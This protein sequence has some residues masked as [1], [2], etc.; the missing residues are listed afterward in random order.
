MLALD[1]FV[2][3]VILV[4]SLGLAVRY[5]VETLEKGLI[6]NLHNVAQI[7][8]N[9]AEVKAALAEGRISP[10]LEK[11]LDEVLA[12]Q[13]DID[14]ITVADVNSIRLYHPDKARVGQ[15]FVGGD[16]GPAILGENYHSFGS[17][18]LGYQSRYFYPVVDQKGQA[19]GFV[20][21]SALMD[22][23][24]ALRQGV[25]WVHLKTLGLVFLISTAL[26]VL[27]SISVKRSLLGFEPAQ[28]ARI[29][30]QRQEVIDSLEEGLL[31]IDERGSVILVNSAAINILNLRNKVL[32]GEDVDRILPELK[33]KESLSGRKEHNF[34]LVDDDINAICNKLPI[35][36]HDRLVGAL[37]II[38]DRTELTSLAERITGFNHLLEALR[39][40]THEFKNQLHVILGLLRSGA[41]EEAKKYVAENS[42][43]QGETLSAVAKNIENRT[44]GALI[45][46]KI[47]RCNELG[48]RLRVVAES[49]IP[50]HSRFLSTKSLITLVGNLVDNAIEAIVAAELQIGPNG[51]DESPREI[52]LFVREDELG[53]IITVDDTGVGCSPEEI[54][55]MSGPGYSTKGPGRG[56]GL[57]LIRAVVDSGRGQMTI[58]SDKGVGTTMELV[59]REPRLGAGEMDRGGVRC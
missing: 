59:F 6:D 46:G 5:S 29:F 55:L 11:Y 31:A 22:N 32:M 15:K 39:A 47:N 26:L 52:S 49:Q 35:K 16:E 53:L 43:F 7:L 54:A 18:T 41:Y 2:A 13:R 21:V 27:L 8:A 50:R 9:D 30:L 37:A 33:L 34:T 48:V 19:L 57:S 14:V 3:A 51:E 28:I 38:R 4:L 36:S 10:E 56:L 17:G 42:Q 25:V 24:A 12:K 20:H 58:D 40:N 44:L 1:I 45:L 23:V